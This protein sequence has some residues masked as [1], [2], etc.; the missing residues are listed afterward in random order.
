[1]PASDLGVGDREVAVLDVTPADDDTE[2]TLT[3][4][5]PDGDSSDVPLT[6]GTLLPV[7]GEDYNT[8]RWTSTDPITYDVP[9]RWVLH[10][11]VTGT[12]AGA[13]DQEIYVVASPVGGLADWTPGRSRVANYVPGRT[14]VA[15]AGANS[16]QLTFTSQTK[17]TGIQVDRLIA[18]AVAWVLARTGTIHS[19]LSEMA[20]SVAAI[21][22]AGM[23]ELGYPDRDAAVKQVSSNTAEAL[24]A[25]AKAMRDDLI[26]ANQ[27]AGEAPVNVS[28][29]FLPVYSFP[30]PVPWGDTYL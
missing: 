11:D 26:I 25:Q 17:P 30:A 27:A 12:G 15:V 13:E 9:D 18:D 28:A 3:A 6:P 2:V 8:Q 21:R 22:T 16:A 1:M 19:S 5:R 20:A 14:L 4:Y 24:L 7:A 29:G 23:V 10:W